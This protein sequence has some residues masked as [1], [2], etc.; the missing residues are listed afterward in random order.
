MES[1]DR[2]SEFQEQSKDEEQPTPWPA[3]VWGIFILIVGM[4]L[5]VY[6]GFLEQQGGSMGM[7][8]LFV[9]VYDLG[10]RWGLLGL[11]LALSSVFFVLEIRERRNRRH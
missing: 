7:P 4:G 2:S 5:F 8:E 3:Y 9:L 1:K 11:F 6:L 10:G